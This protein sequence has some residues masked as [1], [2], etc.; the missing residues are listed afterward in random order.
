LSRLPID[1]LKIDRSFVA[2]LGHEPESD[3]LVQTIVALAHALRLSVT[4]EGIEHAHQAHQLQALGCT[5]GQGYLFARPMPASDLAF[6]EVLTA[7]PR[8]A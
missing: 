3:A 5:R 1:T 7:L 6:F 2:G 8:A 4:A